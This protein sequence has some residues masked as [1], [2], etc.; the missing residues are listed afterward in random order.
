VSPAEKPPLIA[1][2]VA[3]L[4]GF[5]LFLFGSSFLAMPM[6]SPPGPGLEILLRMLMIPLPLTLAALGYLTVHR[7]FDRTAGKDEPSPYR[8]ATS[9][10]HFLWCVLEPLVACTTLLSLYARFNY[11]SSF[12]PLDAVMAFGTGVAP[13]LLFLTA[14]G[15]IRKHPA[16]AILGLLTALAVPFAAR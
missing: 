3:P 7:A 14:L 15:L 10:A 5:F 12:S 16:Q 6:I 2:I 11:F 1:Q 8:I 9:P 4:A 13:W